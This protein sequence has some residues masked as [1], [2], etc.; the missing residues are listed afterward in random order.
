MTTRE[1]L[2]YNVTE[3][4]KII[5]AKNCQKVICSLFFCKAKDILKPNGKD[6]ANIVNANIVLKSRFFSGGLY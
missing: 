4:L 6:N 2:Q 5:F 3:F 1:K